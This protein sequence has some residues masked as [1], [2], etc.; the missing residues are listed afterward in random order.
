MTNNLFSA[1][2]NEPKVLVSEALN[3]TEKT[4]YTCPA[5][6]SMRIATATVTNTS[7]DGP[8]N[9]SVSLVKVGDSPGLSNRILSF[10]P[11]GAGDTLSL[12]DM[13]AGAMLGPGD[14]IVARAYTSTATVSFVVTGA[15]SS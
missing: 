5:G 13:H 4:Y 7:Q 2:S 11:L 15:V 1:T 3:N 14:F 9:V 10:Y 12:N 6:A 8:V